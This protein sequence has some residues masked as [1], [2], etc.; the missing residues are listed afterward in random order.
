[1]VRG[2]RRRYGAPFSLHERKEFRT[3]PPCAEVGVP[4][5]A[6]GW[7]EAPPSWEVSPYRDV[8]LWLVFV[9]SFCFDA[10]VSARI[11]PPALATDAIL[12][13]L[14]AVETLRQKLLGAK[15]VFLHIYLLRCA[16]IKTML[17]TV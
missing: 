8:S 7:R 12:I 14:E 16:S 6:P 17:G 13:V 10:S 3:Q 11:V 9:A 4:E 2:I 1:M 5:P 15:I